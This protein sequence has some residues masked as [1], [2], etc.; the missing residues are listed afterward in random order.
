MD[1]TTQIG[2]AEAFRRMHDRSRILVLPNAY[3]AASALIFQH[4]GF[5]AVATTSSGVANSLGYPDGQ[6]ISRAEMLAAIAPIA[7]ALS[8]P[9]SADIEAGYADDSRELA[10]TIKHVIGAG[11][12][13]V[14]IEDSWFGGSAPLYELTAACER[15]RAARAAAAQTGVPIVINART[16]VFLRAIGAPAERFEHA[17]R[18][19]NAYREAG[20]DCLFVPGVHEPDLIARLA[21][22]IDGPINVLAVGATPPVAELERLGVA[23][24]S[25]GGGPARASLTAVRKVAVE[26]LERGTYEAFT[27]DVISHA[28]MN[29]MMTRGKP[30]PD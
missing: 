2:R 24:V 27:K 14:N 12:V 4:A 26:L 29:A 30:A 22:A 13:G 9:L 8:I 11:A 28:D 25:I 20:A 16:D 6:A 17:A 18:R 3:D 7:A 10:E 5:K 23:R 1:L 19:A 15:I 21:A